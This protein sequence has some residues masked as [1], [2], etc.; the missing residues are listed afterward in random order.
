MQRVQHACNGH[1]GVALFVGGQFGPRKVESSSRKPSKDHPGQIVVAPEANDSGV[2]D[3]RRQ[4]LEKFALSPQSI[5]LSLPAHP[6]YQ[7]VGEPR[8][9]GPTFH[10][11]CVAKVICELTLHSREAHAVIIHHRAT[12]GPSGSSHHDSDVDGANSPPVTDVKR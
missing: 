5:A 4:G 10:Q 12:V 9:V 2:R 3:R 8:V 6:E 1:D 11:N 7:I